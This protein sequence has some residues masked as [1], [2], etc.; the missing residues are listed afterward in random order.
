[1]RQGCEREAGKQKHNHAKHRVLI[2]DRHTCFLVDFGLR[3]RRKGFL[4]LQ[5]LHFR[6]SLDHVDHLPI[7]SESF[8]RRGK[9]ICKIIPQTTGQGDRVSQKMKRSGLPKV[10][11]SR[12]TLRRFSVLELGCPNPHQDQLLPSRFGGLWRDVYS[13]RQAVAFQ[14]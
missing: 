1:V 7:P 13:Q 10:S 12:V 8:T 9:K 5:L 11:L 4:L 6:F 3:W 2:F 14:G